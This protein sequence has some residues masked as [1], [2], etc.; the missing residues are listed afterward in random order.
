MNLEVISYP[1]A[2][3][4]DVHGPEIKSYNVSQIK[5]KNTKPEMCRSESSFFTT[6]YNTGSVTRKCTYNPLKEKNYNITGVAYPPV[7][8]PN[9]IKFIQE[10]IIC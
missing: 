2:E 9:T 5:G 7:S 4:A 6:V 3:M 10:L 1:Y 8:K